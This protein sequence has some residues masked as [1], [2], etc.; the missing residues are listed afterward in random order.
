MSEGRAPGFGQFLDVALHQ[1]GL[2]KGPFHQRGIVG[3]M[4]G[5]LERVDPPDLVA[6]LRRDPVERGADI[7][8]VVA[9]AHGERLADR[10]GDFP[11]RRSWPEL[12][13]AFARCGDAAGD[14]RIEFWRSARLDILRGEARWCM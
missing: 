11:R 8:G 4:T 5:S 6:R 3:R 9:R 10:F 2:R 12:A 14:S 13:R 7:G 1:P